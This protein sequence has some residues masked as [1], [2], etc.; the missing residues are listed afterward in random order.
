MPASGSGKGVG[1]VTGISGV[2]IEAGSEFVGWS[3]QGWIKRRER[4]RGKS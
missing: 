2:R 1:E 4:R 3:K